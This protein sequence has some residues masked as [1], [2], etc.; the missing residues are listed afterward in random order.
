MRVWLTYGQLFHYRKSSDLELTSLL[1]GLRPLI[2]HIPAQWG[3]NF[4]YISTYLYL[5]LGEQGLH[6]KRLAH[7][8][9][10]PGLK[11]RPSW[12]WATCANHNIIQYVCVCVYLPSCI[13]QGLSRAHI[14][15]SPY[16]YIFNIS[17]NFCTLAAVT[18]SSLNP[19]QTS[20][21]LCGKLYF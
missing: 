16:L 21:V 6:I 14:V 1:V 2:Y 12:L 20:T 5:L 11:P 18:I 17:L 15:L 4:S 13:I 3:F 19:F 8:P 9:H 7:L 10:C